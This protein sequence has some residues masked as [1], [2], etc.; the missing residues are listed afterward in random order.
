M[1]CPVYMATSHDKYELPICVCDSM[2]DLAL[3]VGVTFSTVARGVKADEMGRHS[4]YMR[5]WI[6]LDEK[7][8]AEHM[9]RVKNARLRAGPLAV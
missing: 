3:A 4:H 2:R 5:V 1:K 7:E 8:A 9:E 6:D